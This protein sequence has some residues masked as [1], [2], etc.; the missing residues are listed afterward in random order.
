MNATT[1]CEYHRSGLLPDER[2]SLDSR[3]GWTSAVDM[4]SEMLGAGSSQD[5]SA[6]QK[7]RAVSQTQSITTGLLG[8]RFLCLLSIVLLTILTVDRAQAQAIPVLRLPTR[9]SAFTTFTDAKPHLGYY[10]DHA[11]WGLTAGGM[12]QLPRLGGLEV[13]GS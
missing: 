4:A 11:V 10:D 9:F 8:A 7:R 12:M 5:V 13:R 3:R 1:L 6:D 2:V